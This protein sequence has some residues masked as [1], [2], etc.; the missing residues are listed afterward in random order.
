V[1]EFEKNTNKY[2]PFRMQKLA[3]I[4]MPT[5]VDEYAKMFDKNPVPPNDFVGWF[6]I[7]LCAKDRDE[8]QRCL[9]LGVELG[10]QDDIKSGFNL[11]AMHFGTT[12][13]ELLSSDIGDIGW[14]I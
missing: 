7:I 2:N 8:L 3:H 9:M 13:E 5:Y 6:A 12:I 4:D 14:L 1:N 11:A 10:R